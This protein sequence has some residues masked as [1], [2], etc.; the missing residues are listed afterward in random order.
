MVSLAASQMAF[1]SFSLFE[2]GKNRRRSE[3]ETRLATR[4]ATRLRKE[5]IIIGGEDG[6]LKLR[7]GTMH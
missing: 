7:G 4:L 2:N 3:K 1:L 5:K 6:N